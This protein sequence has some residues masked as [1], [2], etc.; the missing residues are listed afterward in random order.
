M[1]KEKVNTEDLICE[2]EKLPAIWNPSCEEYGNRIEKQNAWNDVLLKLIPDFED[3]PL[4]E[5]K[6]IRKLFIIFY[7]FVHT[8]FRLTRSGGFMR[9]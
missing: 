9:H 2:V 3:K 7:Y 1:V 5:K 4:T 8:F 6:E